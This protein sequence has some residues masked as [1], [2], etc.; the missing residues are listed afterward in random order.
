MFRFKQL[1]RKAGNKIRSG[2]GESLS[3]VL[4]ALLISA[5]GLTM[6]AVMI[7]SSGRILARS[8]ENFRTY[9]GAENELSQQAEEISS[10]AVA[11]GAGICYVYEVSQGT[12]NKTTLR[13]GASADGGIEV[14]YYIYEPRNGKYVISYKAD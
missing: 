14:R 8:Q 3:E 5:L 1:I 4:I 2:A 9:A 10:D 6:L 12:A 13:D 11:S 7:T